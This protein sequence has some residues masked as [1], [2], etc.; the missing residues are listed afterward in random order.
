MDQNREILKEKKRKRLTYFFIIAFFGTLIF[1]TL[2]TS[3]GTPLTKEVEIDGKLIFTFQEKSHYLIVLN[4]DILTGFEL[5]DQLRRNFVTGD[6]L[7]K[8]SGSSVIEITRNDSTFNLPI[9]F[10]KAEETAKRKKEYYEKK[11]R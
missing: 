8:S 5:A 10:Q 4:N 2:L 7:F 6:R 11:R 3:T 9:D 1:L